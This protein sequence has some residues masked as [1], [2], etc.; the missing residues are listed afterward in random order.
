M[1]LYADIVRID[2]EQRMVWGYASTEA[3]A[4][5]G[6]IITRDALSD[7]LDDYMK[8]ANIRE[9]H[10]QSAVGIARE[11]NVDDVGLYV[12]AHI[13]DD[14]A[15]NK[16]QRKVYKGFSLGGKATKRDDIDRTIVRGLTIN[17]ISL[18]DRPADPGAVFDVWRSAEHS[19]NAMK[20]SAAKIVPAEETVV[21]TSDQVE[22]IDTA[23]VP[24][25]ATAE[26]IAAAETVVEDP[27]ARAAEAAAKANASA[28]DAVSKVE[29]VLTVTAMP[30][31]DIRRGMGGVSQLG[32]LL[33]ELSYIVMDTAFEA[34]IEGDGSRV[35]AKLRAALGLL[36]EAYRD[37]SAEE[38]AEL[39]ANVDAV[40]MIENGVI[41]FSAVAGDI[42][43]AAKVELTP[44][45]SKRLADTAGLL[46]ERGWLAKPEA[47]PAD[48]DAAAAAAADIT[49]VAGERDKAVA[50]NDVLLRALTESTENTTKL[51]SRVDGL[52][53][54]I[55]RMKLHAAPAKTAASAVIAVSKEE[56]VAGITRTAAATLSD[57]DVTRALEA[58][59]KEQRDLAITRAALAKPIL[60]RR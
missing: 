12:G 46:V 4:A 43:R 20:S 8:F 34:Q 11:G 7:A 48:G 16:V 47:V 58:M 27:I 21:E 3:R 29:R 30:G 10:Q 50:D 53:S 54:E 56:D 32:Y 2:E 14:V 52:F 31:A 26:V 24:A 18:V 1:N 44:E 55:E 23:I 40:I 15:W 42:E 60:I 6:M 59:P 51:V 28:T 41:A 57:D 5:D 13:V 39:V 9:M 38:V 36:A 45:L 49:R 35:P 22:R 37:M 17:E 33:S 25:A 19:E